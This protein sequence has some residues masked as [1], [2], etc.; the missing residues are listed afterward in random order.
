M[1]SVTQDRSIVEGYRS[2]LEEKIAEQLRRAG[3]PVLYEAHKLH[4]TQPAKPRTYTPDFILKNGMVVE[5]KGRFVAADRQKHLFIKA[6]TPVSTSGSCSPIP[7]PASGRPAPPPMPCGVRRTASSTPRSG[8]RRSGLKSLR[9]PCVSL[10]P[11]W[12][13]AGPRQTDLRRTL[14]GGGARCPSSPAFKHLKNQKE[15]RGF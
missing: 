5:S 11:S 12:R 2:G 8:Y 9:F 6:V 13:W 15:L 4:Y 14:Y 10:R 3:H 7:T 1:A